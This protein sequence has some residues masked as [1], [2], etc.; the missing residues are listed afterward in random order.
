MQFTATKL[1]TGSIV[2]AALNIPLLSPATAVLEPHARYVP[3]RD[4][5][6][7][8]EGSPRNELSGIGT[9]HWLQIFRFDPAPLGELSGFRATTPREEIV[10]EIRGW[11]LQEA[12]WDGEGAEE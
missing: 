8:L 3:A 12:N 11:A 9:A 7:S 2:A 6:S 10:G 1:G 4:S 5:R